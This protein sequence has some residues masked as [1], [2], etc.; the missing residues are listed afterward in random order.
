MIIERYEELNSTH[1]YIK[2]NYKKYNSNVAII[3]N[4]QTAGIGTNGRSWFTGSDKNIAMSMLYK[5]SCKVEELEGLTVKIAEILKKVIFDLYD[6]E[7][8][9]KKPNDLMLNNKKICGI[10]TEINSM[11]NK[12]NYLI[13]SIGFNVNESNFPNELENIATSLYKE[14]GKEFDKEEILQRFIMSLDNII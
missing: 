10:L 7:L 13:I 4:R 2:E 6:I 1:K 9:I 5:T 14:I 8:R 12:I 3:A 11:G